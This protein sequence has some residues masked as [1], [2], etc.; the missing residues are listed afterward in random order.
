MEGNSHD[1][2]EY[3]TC[4]FDK[5]CTD[6]TDTTEGIEEGYT[7]LQFSLNHENTMS[8]STTYTELQT[9]AVAIDH[10]YTQLN[11]DTDGTIQ[12]NS[13]LGNGNYEN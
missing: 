2:T 1:V 5:N 6:P 7:E 13:E 4:N 9:A 12:S 3:E 11:P 8:P 10:G